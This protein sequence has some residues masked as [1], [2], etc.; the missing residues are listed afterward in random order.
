MADLDDLNIDSITD[1]SK[2]EAIELL[3]QV[4]LGRRTPVK[5]TSK[6]ST[7]KQL[8]KLKQTPE[9]SAEQAAALL[10]L[11]GGSND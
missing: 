7:P 9:I 8:R 2:D 5:M 11:L 10:K 1:M 4:R 6:K 3:R